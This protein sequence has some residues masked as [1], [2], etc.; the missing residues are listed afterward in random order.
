MK[1]P[2]QSATVAGILGVLTVLLPL[3]AQNP[4]QSPAAAQQANPAQ[5]GQR[6]PVIRV[7][8]NQVVIPV[9]VK[10]GGGRLVADLERGDFR[11]F[12]DNVE[13]RIA[14]FSAEAAP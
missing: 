13:Q 3:E 7:P 14:F 12:E 2:R 4:A 8:V 5:G 10:D 11:I 9:T 6:P 1:S